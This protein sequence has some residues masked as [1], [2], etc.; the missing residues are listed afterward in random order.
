DGRISTYF[1]TTFGRATRETACSCE[2]KM[3]P[4]LSQ[5]LHLLNGDTVNS[6]M[7]QGGLIPALQKEGLTPPQIVERLYIRCLSRKPTE[8]ELAALAPL[9]AEGTDVN[10]GLQDIFWALLNSREFLFNH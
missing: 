6:K 4:T 3:E 2:V 7:A 8:A 10:Q 5:A 1:L 9:I